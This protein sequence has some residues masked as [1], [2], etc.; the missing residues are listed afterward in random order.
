MTS[1]RVLL[2][3][4]VQI[5]LIPGLPAP[6]TI[7]QNIALVLDH[8]RRAEQSPRIIHLRNCGE[9]GDPDEEGT[10]TW[11][12]LHP[13]LADEL[14]LNKRKSNAFAG[15]TLAGEIGTEAEIVVVGLLSEFSIKSTCK[16]ALQRGNTVFLMT[17]A[18]GTYDHKDLV[19]A[20]RVIPA[21]KIQAQ[22]EEELDKAGAI[23]LDMKYLPGLFEG[24]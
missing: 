11:E 10:P 15:T 20:G 1:R 7:L 9:A 6:E 14:V 4:N 5:G 22:V 2:V 21:E 18:H 24:R 8:A 19:E 3:V 16:A 17:G 23:I 13:P 12:L